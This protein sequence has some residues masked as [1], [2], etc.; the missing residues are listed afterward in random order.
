MSKESCEDCIKFD[1]TKDKDE[2]NK[3][4]SAK[5]CGLGCVKSL[6]KKLNNLNNPNVVSEKEKGELNDTFERYFHIG[7]DGEIEGKPIIDDVKSNFS[8]IETT[9]EALKIENFCNN[10]ANDSKGNSAF[11]RGI[12]NKDAQIS[13]EKRP[14]ERDGNILQVYFNKPFFEGESKQYG[15]I[16]YDYKNIHFDYPDDSRARTLIH[17]ASHE[18][19]FKDDKTEGY[20]KDEIYMSKDGSTHY[21]EKYDNG[22]PKKDENN[23]DIYHPVETSPA[24]R[25]ELNDGYSWVAKAN[26]PCDAKA[27]AKTEEADVIRKAHQP[28]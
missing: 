21:K 8:N 22:I 7:L 20:G 28:K 27:A 10:T 15:E 4:E 18:G 11:I 5:K 9:M 1:E 19:T 17:E 23:N 2:L 25:L 3:I 13:D 14:W 12:D 16:D 24:Q 26:C 6:N